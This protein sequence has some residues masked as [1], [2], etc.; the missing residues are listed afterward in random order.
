MP[1]ENNKKA[2]ALARPAPTVRVRPGPDEPLIEVGQWYWVSTADQEADV[3]RSAW[4][5]CVTRIGSNY[6]K[7]EGPAHKYAKST[8]GERVHLDE[9]AK[10]CVLEM[11]PETYLRGKVEAH[12]RRVNELLNDIKQLTAS[13]GISP[14][15]LREASAEAN[16][17]AQALTVMHGTQD[18]K[19][20]KADL[21][22]AKENTLP[23]LF[24]QVE[25]EHEMMAHWMQA[26]LIPFQAQAKGLARHTEAIKDR[27]FIVELY[28]GLCETLVQ[29]QDGDTAEAATKLSLFQRRHYMDEECLA[30][31]EAGGM[32]FQNIEAFNDWLL[33]P[34]NL[35]RILPYP[36]SVVA[37]RVR[38]HRY[39]YEGHDQAPVTIWQF[40]QLWHEEKANAKTY[41]YFRNGEQVFYLATG[42][43]FGSQLFPDR[44]HAELESK[45]L[46]VELGHST[47]SRHIKAVVTTSHVEFANKRWKDKVRAYKARKREHRKAVAAWKVLSPEEQEKAGHEPWFSH[48]LDDHDK[49]R[50]EPLTPESVYYDDAMKM[51]NDEIK[52][53]NRVATVL[54][55]VLDRSPAFHPHPP[56][57]LFTRE[58]FEAGVHLVYD[59]TRALT[60]GDAP[61]FEAYRAQCNKGIRA[62]SMTIGQDDFWQRAEA[63]K[64]NKRRANDWRRSR[65]YSRELVHFRPYGNPGP[66]RVARVVRVMRNGDCIFEWTRERQRYRFYSNDSEKP[67]LCRVRVP[68]SKLFNVDAYE[69]G[70]FHIFFDDPRTRVDYVKWAPFLLAAEDYVAERRRKWNNEAK[71]EP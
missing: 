54:Q 26:S 56:W 29:I 33:R 28:A 55:G 39:D 42:I 7:L 61:D 50:F 35:K 71:E 43:E 36:R 51:L 4:L 27:I 44:E 62:G 16:A 67:I 25:H 10:R 53:H 37:F 9:F 24:K 66:G 63:V 30:N 2:D 1:N 11:D 20:Y 21:I 23:E 3:T 52:A 40:I 60:T 31:Y 34:D 49:P 18:V 69:P 5:G 57:Q 47:N 15:A 12:Q 6:V 46:W 58:G 45:D 14:L 59:Q 38:H 22:K 8:F 13:L 70:D 48:Y 68:R 65:D 17:S 32:T 64:E 19:Q 41:L